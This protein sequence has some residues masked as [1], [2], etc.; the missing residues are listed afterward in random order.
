M[1]TSVRSKRVVFMNN[2]I[3]IAIDAMGGDNS[4]NKVIECI[5]LHSKSSNNVKYKVYGNLNL[6]KPFNSIRYL[7]SSVSL[8]LM[9]FPRQP[10]L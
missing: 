5:S 9:I 10:I 3:T 1:V 6:I 7:P 2:T 8:K 4:P